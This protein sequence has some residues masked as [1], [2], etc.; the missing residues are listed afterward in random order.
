MN[1]LRWSVAPEDSRIRELHV[2]GLE[3]QA[4]CLAPNYWYWS[5]RTSDGWFIAQ[6]NRETCDGAKLAALI[7]A[8]KELADRGVL[9]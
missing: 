1:R 7:A 2:Q 5:V 9:L 3:L 6:G 8:E 4:Q